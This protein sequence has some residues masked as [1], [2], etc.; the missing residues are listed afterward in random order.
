M[1]EILGI[2]NNFQAIFDQAKGN[3]AEFESNEFI[4]LLESQLNNDE[5]S[6]INDVNNNSNNI[7]GFEEVATDFEA[8]F[9]SQMLNL[10][11]DEIETNEL[12]GGGKA[13]EMFKSFLIDEYANE[14][15]KQGGIGIAENV[16]NDL[17]V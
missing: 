7:E 13:E 11:F 17:L 6:P 16:I 10:M 12:F 15:A 1:N 5:H 2:N 9:I 14:F 8:Q 4:Q 3:I